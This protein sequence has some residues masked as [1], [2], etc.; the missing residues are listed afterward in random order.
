MTRAGGINGTAAANAFVSTG[1]SVNSSFSTAVTDEDYLVFTIA[2]AAN[3]SMTFTSVVSR[4]QRSTTGPTNAAW[5]FITSGVTNTSETISVPTSAAN[6]TTTTGLVTNVTSALEVRLV[7]FN[8]GASGG[9]FRLIG[10][11]GS[12]SAA[13]SFEGTTTLRSA[14]TL[15]WDGGRGVANWTAYSGT[16]AN[17]ANWDGNSTP[18]NGDSLLFVGTTQ[19]NTTNDVSSLLANAIVFNNTAGTFAISGNALTVSNGITNLSAN[20]QTFSNAVTLGAA[21]TFNA[22]AGNLAFAGNVVNAGNALTVDGSENT[23][24]SGALSGVGGLVKSGAGTLTL[25]GANSYS[26]GRRRSDLDRSLRRCPL[27]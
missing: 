23:A 17:Q 21:Q 24:I 20:A 22:S 8:A 11:N 18:L 5:S 14:S 16:N 27:K 15:T 12:G 26:G 3:Y 9:T 4:H 1:F 25:G 2:P 6:R 10:T 19:T 13:T 7:G